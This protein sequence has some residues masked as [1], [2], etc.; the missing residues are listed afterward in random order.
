MQ[1]FFA[2]WPEDRVRLALAPHRLECARM[3]GG[4]P[5][6]PVT[7]HVTLAYVGR[8]SEDRIPLLKEIAGSIRMPTFDYDIDLAGCFEGAG[9]AWLS[10]DA[11]PKALHKLHQKLQAAIASQGFEIDTRKFRPHITVARNI[12]HA[13]EPYPVTP[14]KWTVRQFSLVGAKRNDGGTHYEVLETWSLGDES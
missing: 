8:V 13:F 14:V 10:S 9:V 11:P 4:R 1:L 2:L 12:A 5:T 3:T 6:L 7:L